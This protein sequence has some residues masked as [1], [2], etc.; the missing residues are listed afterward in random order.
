MNINK[1]RRELSLRD[2][3]KYKAKMARRLQGRPIP[4]DEAEA[5]E[6]GNE[7]ESRNRPDNER[8]IAAAL[9]FECQENAYEALRRFKR[10][11]PDKM[12]R[13]TWLH[14]N[15]FSRNGQKFK[16][17]N[18]VKN[19][20]NVAERPRPART[21]ENAAILMQQIRAE[22]DL[23]P[24]EPRM[25]SRRNPLSEQ[26]SCSSFLRLKE[27]MKLWY[28]HIMKGQKLTPIDNLNRVQFCRKNQDAAKIP[29]R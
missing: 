12:G 21:P 3:E 6:N 28:Y 18:T 22:I 13:S 19:Q 7:I 1:V 25:S 8:S 2:F 23:G 5:D 4:E 9:Y 11:Y 16:E 20:H 26:I 29:P 14:P 10:R 27:D 17:K 15:F 24:R